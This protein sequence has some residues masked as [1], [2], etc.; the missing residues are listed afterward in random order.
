MIRG[1]KRKLDSTPSKRFDVG[2]SIHNRFDIEVLDAVSGQVKQKAFAENVVCSNL[3][4]R[5]C[6]GSAWNSYI[7]YGDGSGTPSASDTS[8]FSF[9]GSASS[10][11]H[12]MDYDYDNKVFTCTKKVVIDETTAVGKTLTEVG[13]G[14]SSGSATLCTHAMLKDM[15]GNPV[16]LAKTNTDIFNIYATVF[17]HIV[18]PSEHVRML[19]PHR[20]NGRWYEVGIMQFFSGLVTAP[21]LN[22]PIM[23]GTV[24][25]ATSGYKSLTL[26]SD[27]T[28]RKLTY[29]AARL[30]AS[31][32][33]TGGLPSLMFRAAQSSSAGY[34]AIDIVFDIDP[35]DGWFRGTHVDGEAIGTG[36]GITVDFATKF[37]FATNAKVYVDGVETPAT[38]DYINHALLRSKSDYSC[39]AQPMWSYFRLLRAPEVGYGYH[40]NTYYV[41]PITYY[42]PSA[43]G[44]YCIGRMSEYPSVFEN[45]LYKTHGVSKF[46]CPPSTI[47]VS[48]DLVNWV[49]LC[50]HSST[51]STNSITVTVPDEYQNY[52]YWSFQ[53]H[54]S[55]P[56]SGNCRTATIYANTDLASMV[57]NIHFS[58]PPPAGAVIT[59]DYDA[60]CVGKDENHVF[61][62]S[63]T[64]TFNEYV[65]S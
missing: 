2:T 6:G 59:A 47:K 61:D 27:L 64:F 53:S 28:N 16:S 54:V 32:F 37:G 13:I 45:V 8:L 38:V 46:G 44:G 14:Y 33:N 1:N 40:N 30:A 49:T 63:V 31:E 25:C 52:R 22:V 65:E 29:T 50:D 60:I 42:K 39:L 26:E 5:L 21:T 41:A 9:L 62:F 58:E 10:E 36:D 19:A 11:I 4:T 56:L 23:L 35:K 15:N 7:H 43:G 17:I 34:G 51:T 20:Y 55:G 57:N 18:T 48:N 12:N 24:P 3:W